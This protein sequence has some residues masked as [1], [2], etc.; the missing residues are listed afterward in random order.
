[1]LR[2]VRGV[3]LRRRTWKKLHYKEKCSR[4]TIAVLQ[5]QA[6]R[7]RTSIEIKEKVKCLKCRIEY[8]SRMYSSCPLCEMRQKFLD[9]TKENIKPYQIDQ[10]N[11]TWNLRKG[12]EIEFGELDGNSITWIVL[13][14]IKNK[15]LLL[16]KYGLA[17]MPYNN[18]M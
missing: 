4:P 9:K 12:D 16:A 18:K 5:N 7:Y 15:V 17:Y 13:G 1:M 6:R 8:D 11:V 3:E 2:V 10:E 14:T